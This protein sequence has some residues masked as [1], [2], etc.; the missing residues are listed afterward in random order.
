MGLQTA[1][2]IEQ[3]HLHILID[4][5]PKVPNRNHAVAGTGPSPARDPRGARPAI[6]STPT[7]LMSSR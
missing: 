4:N 2:G 5:N 7:T 3:D 6:L 1:A